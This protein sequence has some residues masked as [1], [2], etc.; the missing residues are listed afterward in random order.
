MKRWIFTPPLSPQVLNTGRRSLFG[1]STTGNEDGITCDTASTRK[2]LGELQV[3]YSGFGID[4]FQYFQH[5]MPTVDNSDLRF[6]RVRLN[7]EL[8]RIIN[9]TPKSAVRQFIILHTLIHSDLFLLLSDE[10]H[11]AKFEEYA[12]RDTGGDSVRSKTSSSMYASRED[13]C[14]STL[15]H[16]LPSL[17]KHIGCK[18]SAL[19]QSRG[20]ALKV[21]QKIR[22]AL[23]NVLTASPFRVPVENA[24][25]VT[26]STVGPVIDAVGQALTARCPSGAG[27]K[28]RFE[29]YSF[30]ANM[31]RLIQ[32]HHGEYFRA[33]LPRRSRDQALLSLWIAASGQGKIKCSALLCHSARSIIC[34]YFTFFRI[35]KD[36]EEKREMT[37]FFILR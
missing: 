12:G 17:E 6:C 13:Q 16:F 9:L 21:L 7:L 34:H 22:N 8:Q 30:S 3:K 14:L 23:H 24:A 36:P 29:E 27:P 35:L 18:E 33:R 11:S 10:D 28:G 20:N 15:L 2:N 1:G 19:Y 26:N 4:W 37:P 25:A 5:V 32:Y 31:L